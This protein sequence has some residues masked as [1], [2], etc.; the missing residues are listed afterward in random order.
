MIKTRFLLENLLAVVR[1]LCSLTNWFYDSKL[2][3]PPTK[4]QALPVL[5]SN[6]NKIFPS[7]IIWLNY[8]TL[9][10]S[11]FY[12]IHIYNDMA[13]KHLELIGINIIIKANWKVDRKAKKVSNKRRYIFYKNDFFP[14]HV[15][16]WISL[17][18]CWFIAENVI[19]NI[20]RL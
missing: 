14:P 12:A 4:K 19:I 16:Y 18:S 20:L 7:A 15:R 2:N 11:I 17:Y 13:E 6:K 3:S 1:L 10:L 8:F 9:H 5:S